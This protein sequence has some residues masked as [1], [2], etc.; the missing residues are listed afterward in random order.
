MP[1]NQETKRVISEERNPSLIIPFHITKFSPAGSTARDLRPVS[2]CAGHIKRG[3]FSAQKIVHE[4]ET[5][6]G[7]APDVFR[8]R[9]DK[10]KPEES[11]IGRLIRLAKGR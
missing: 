7:T 3:L 11:Y 8:T 1:I 2:E 6:G 9:I 10:V 4:K 5:V